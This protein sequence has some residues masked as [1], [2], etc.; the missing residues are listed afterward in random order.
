MQTFFI[1]GLID[2]FKLPVAVISS[3][4]G[5]LNNIVFVKYS[6]IGY[7]KTVIKLVAFFD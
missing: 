1:L 7:F 2:N 5:V 3:R 4:S 6:T